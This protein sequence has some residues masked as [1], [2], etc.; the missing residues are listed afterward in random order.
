MSAW[1]RQIIQRLPEFRPLAESA[2]NPMALWIELFLPCEEA[3]KR[4][5]DDF[6]R[7]VYAAAHWFL[8][9]PSDDLTTAVVCAF[10]EHLPRSPILWE[11]LPRRMSPSEFRRI[12]P[13]WDYHSTPEEI[14]AQERRVF[15]MRA[16]VARR[17]P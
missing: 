4:S 14:Q 11:D 15:E 3:C 1:R 17:L 10:Y 2:E 16:E 7:R 5:D 8:E 6:V 12:R 9:S 13:C